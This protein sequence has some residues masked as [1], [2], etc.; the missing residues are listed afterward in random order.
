MTH[1]PLTDDQR[2]VMLRQAG[3]TER[4]N[5]PRWMITLSLLLLL[6]A[7]LFLWNA[8]SGW[9][10]DGAA[11]ASAQANELALDNDLDALIKAS[12]PPD[13]GSIVF[14]PPIANPQ[15]RIETLATQAGLDKP[16]P[17]QLNEDPLEGGAVRR[18][19]T[20]REVYS[21]SAGA[22]ITWMAAVE[23]D[24]QGMQVRNLDLRREERRSGWTATV[25]FTRLEKTS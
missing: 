18:N 23:A 14:F 7:A 19:F 13:P 8:W 20:Y 9:R 6:A 3:E 24:I 10:R 16:N 25:E 5:R 12:L 1:P 17:A 2:L 4:S 11:L 15:T 22:L 21:P